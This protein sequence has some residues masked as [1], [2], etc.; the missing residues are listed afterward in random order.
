VFGSRPFVTRSHDRAT[1]LWPLALLSFGESWHN[2]H[3]SDPACARHGADPGQVDIAAEVI[4]IFERLGWATDVHWPT[5]VRLDNH[6]RKQIQDRPDRGQQDQ[7]QP[8]RAL[9]SAGR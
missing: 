1:N 2:M 5:Q 9:Q 7:D 4:R 8:E 3:H 6:R